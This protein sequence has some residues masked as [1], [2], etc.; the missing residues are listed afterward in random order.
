MVDH[1]GLSQQHRTYPQFL[2]RPLFEIW[3]LELR[4]REIES[5]TPTHLIKA[6]ISTMIPVSDDSVE[7]LIPVEF[8]ATPFV[9]LLEEC[10]LPDE[11]KVIVEVGLGA[12]RLKT[13]VGVFISWNFRSLM[14]EI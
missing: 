7:G 14:Y 11:Y 12:R 3:A 4:E 13:H 8:R 6:R 1:P 5:L 2:T 10:K 9:V